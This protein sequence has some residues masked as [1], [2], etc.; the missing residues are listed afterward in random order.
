MQARVGA[1]PPHEPPS[2]H[3]PPN[4]TPP[5]TETHTHTHFAPLTGIIGLGKK[6]GGAKKGICMPAMPAM[7]CMPPP[8]ACLSS[9]C[10]GVCGQGWVGLGWIGGIRSGVPE[11]AGRMSVHRHV[12]ERA[13]RATGAL[14]SVVPSPRCAA[15]AHSMQEC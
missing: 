14:A 1:K 2:T 7:P 12:P 11:N 9:P 13:Q 5:H 3:P 15:F 6:P 8:A 10:S 4:H